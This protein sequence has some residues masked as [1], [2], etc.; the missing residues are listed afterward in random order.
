GS[1]NGR[2]AA[3]EAVN[4]GSN[5]GPRALYWKAVNLGLPHLYPA[6]KKGRGKIGGVKIQVPKP[7]NTL[8]KVEWGVLL[9]MG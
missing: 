9:N 1:S 6:L 7:K 3:F 8:S 4:P 2:T 5:P